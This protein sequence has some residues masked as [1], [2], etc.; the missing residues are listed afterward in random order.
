MKQKASTLVTYLC[1][2]SFLAIGIRGLSAQD[3]SILESR[4]WYASDASGMSLERIAG[5]LGAEYALLVSKNENTERAELYHDGAILK[6]WHRSYLSGGLLSREAYSEGSV[7]TEER[8]YDDEGRLRLERQFFDEGNVEETTYQ[9]ASGRLQSKT[10]SR[11]GEES[12]SM[13]YVY[14]PGGR[15]ASVRD[16][17]DLSFGYS[18]SPM[19]GQSF[20]REGK[21]GLEL[22]SYDQAGRLVR[23]SVYVD[24]VLKSQESREWQDG[25]L[26]QSIVEKDDGTKNT[27]S[28]AAEGVAAGLVTSLSIEL[29]GIVQ[30]LVKRDYDFKGRLERVETI[31]NGQV[32]SST[33]EYDSDDTL[34]ITK[35]FVDGLIESIVSYESP[36]VHTEEL[37]SRGVA[38]VRVR[39]EDGRRVLEEILKDGQVVRSRRF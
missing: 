19:G 4:L 1:L 27:T 13:V 21:D 3:G 22:R 17:R 11:T 33:Y 39:Y 31:A 8:L 5:P 25:T 26:I 20:W 16:S 30:S 9:Y 18:S 28:Y 29:N 36:L 14:A 10:T 24:A 23:V 32:R 7:L 15:L 34:K 37:Y 6:T 12:S 2:A 38:F 35:T